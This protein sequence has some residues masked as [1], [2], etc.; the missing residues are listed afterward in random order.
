MKEDVQIEKLQ[1][2]EALRRQGQ[3]D[4]ER[5][6]AAAALQRVATPRF[7]SPARLSTRTGGKHSMKSNTGTSKANRRK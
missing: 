3:T 7:R 2:I 6:A 4:G 1:K 5:Q